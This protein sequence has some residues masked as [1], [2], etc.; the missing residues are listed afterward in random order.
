MVYTLA[1]LD[2][3]PPISVLSNL[4]NGTNAKKAGKQ[5]ECG[6]KEISNSTLSRGV[7]NAWHCDRIRH[8]YGRNDPSED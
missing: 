5:N 7:C 2:L 1:I 8:S 4:G 3:F 6:G